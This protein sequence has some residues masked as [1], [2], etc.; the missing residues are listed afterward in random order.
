MTLSLIVE[1]LSVE[2]LRGRGM[3]STLLPPLSPLGE[4]DLAFL[5]NGVSITCL[6][7]LMIGLCSFASRMR[8]HSCSTHSLCWTV[9]LAM[10]SSRNTRLLPVDIGHGQEFLD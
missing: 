9:L 2:G 10:H 8:S 3:P 1:G 5:P 7:P 6:W 4:R